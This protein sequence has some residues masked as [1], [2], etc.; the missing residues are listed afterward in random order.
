[1]GDHLGTTLASRIFGEK[2]PQTCMENTWKGMEKIRK[3]GESGTRMRKLTIITSSACAPGRPA[4]VI[5]VALS[6]FL[7]PKLKAF[8]IR[9]KTL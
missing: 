6:P 8:N 5:C 2:L 9:S 4:W 3:K 7:Q 1:V